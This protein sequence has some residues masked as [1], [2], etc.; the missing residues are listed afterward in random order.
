MESSVFNNV[1]GYWNQKFEDL[2]CKRSSLNKGSSCEYLLSEELKTNNF[3]VCICHLFGLTVAQCVKYLGSWGVILFFY[4]VLFNWSSICVLLIDRKKA[5]ED[6]I[7]RSGHE[8][9]FSKQKHLEAADKGHSP[10][11][12]LKTGS[13]AK[14]SVKS[15]SSAKNDSNIGGHCT[16]Y[17][18]KNLEDDTPSE[19]KQMADKTVSLPRKVSSSLLV[20]VCMYTC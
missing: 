18:S 8:S 14:T 16:R 15:T 9:E 11:Q 5:L 17:K 6:V 19:S 10:A 2:W 4:K 7:Q 20:E 12:K 13:G 1:K 3:F